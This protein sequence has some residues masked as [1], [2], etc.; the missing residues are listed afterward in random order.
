MTCET[1]IDDGGSSAVEAVAGASDVMRPD[2]VVVDVLDGLCGG[3]G[4][5]CPAEMLTGCASYCF[6]SWGGSTVWPNC[7]CY[8]R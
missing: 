7:D 3:C 4:V 1:L 2:C 8:S 5:V 6:H